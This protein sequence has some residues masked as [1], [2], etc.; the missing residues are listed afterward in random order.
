MYWVL[1]NL[2]LEEKEN[3][4]SA[5]QKQDTENID[6]F[7]FLFYQFHGISVSHCELHQ[8]LWRVDEAPILMSLFL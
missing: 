3:M 8:S 1:Q 5:L 7:V 4:V 6:V 2:S